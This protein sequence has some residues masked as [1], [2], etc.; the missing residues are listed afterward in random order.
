MARSIGDRITR[1]THLSLRVCNGCHASIVS[2]LP[3]S[4]FHYHSILQMPLFAATQAA[5]IAVVA[6]VAAAS[7]SA[8]VAVTGYLSH[9]L[10]LAH[11][12][13]TVIKSKP[14][15]LPFLLPLLAFHFLLSGV[16]LFSTSPLF[17]SFISPYSTLHSRKMS[18]NATCDPWLG[19]FL[20]SSPIQFYFSSTC[21]H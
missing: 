7:A 5:A 16:F 17:H 15:S 12:S 21:H 13:I 10:L 14:L 20:L 2:F 9:F 3:S 19:M 4:F 6:V 1:P 11:L 8:S 18:V